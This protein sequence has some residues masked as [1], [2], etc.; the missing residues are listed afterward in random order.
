MEVQTSAF[1]LNCVR[2][3]EIRRKPLRIM[4]GV[5]GLEPVLITGFSLGK[6]AQTSASKQYSLISV[7]QRLQDDRLNLRCLFVSFVSTAY[8]L[9]PV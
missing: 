8:Q 6:I 1:C 2:P 9:P 5:A 4:A 3:S 7:N